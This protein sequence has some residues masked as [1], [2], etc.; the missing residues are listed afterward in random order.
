MNSSPNT[1]DS[2]LKAPDVIIGRIE[3]YL[4]TADIEEFVRHFFSLHSDALNDL[5]AAGKDG[6]VVVKPNWVQ[7]NHENLPDVWEPVITHPS[8]ILAVVKVLCEKM[9]NCGTICIC[10]APITHANFTD[11]LSRG[12]LLPQ[13]DQIRTKWPKIK[14]EILDLRRE[15]WE[16]KEQVVIRRMPNPPDPRGYVQLNLGKQSLFYGH[17]G[18]G[19]YYGADYDTK[20][21]NEHHHGETQEY[22]LAGTPMCC[23]LFVNLPKLK[24][25]KKTG[26]TCSLKNLVGINGDKNWLPHHTKGSPETKGDEF[27]SMPFMVR[28]ERLIKT[29]GQRLALKLPLLG[30]W[31]YRKMRSAGKAVMGDSDNSVRNGNWKGNDTCWRMA[32]DLNRAL[33]FG[34]QDGS[35]KREAKPY[36]AIVDGIIG[37]EGNGPLCPSPVES[38]VLFGGR[39]PAAVDAVASKLAGFNPNELPLVSEAFEPHIWRVGQC[40]LDEVTAL[41]LQSNQL[42]RLQDIA[43]AVNGGFKPHFGWKALAS[44][45]KS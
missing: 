5:L 11:L 31:V 8:L 18:E 33:L 40:S 39:N 27:P 16:T 9:Q 12:D 25:H 19:R 41:E 45:C 6:L 36:L 13:L 24:T 17:P 37:G 4:G 30:P 43:A 34:N 35:W 22:L 10:D 38:K 21:V 29:A 3:S 42:L 26:I 32:L 23:H 44:D 14:I 1:V 28:A 15:V 2:R 7:Q 20:V